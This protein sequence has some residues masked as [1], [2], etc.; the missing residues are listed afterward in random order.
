M[1]TKNILFA[2]VVSG[3]AMFGVSAPAQAGLLSP[4]QNI[5]NQN[6]LILNFDFQGTYVL[7]SSNGTIAQ[8][9]RSG[10]P[11]GGT[12]SLDLF[13]MGGYAD[14]VGDFNTT[15]DPD[16][17][18]PFTAT[19]PLSAYVDLLGSGICDGAPMCASS[20]INFKLPIFSDPINV[21]ADF[22]LDP[23]TPFSNFDPNNPMASLMGL[24]TTQLG[25]QFKISSIDTDG[26]GRPGTQ[27]V[28]GPFNGFTPSFN[29]VA[30]L[31]GITLG[32]ALANP[33]LPAP[34]DFN[35]VLTAP[36]PEPGEWA[37]LLAGLGLVAFKVRGRR[38]A[39]TA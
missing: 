33:N 19:G 2:G 26:D 5:I 12:I 8:R 36:V 25:L 16:G 11:I 13:T 32:Q 9:P 28:G 30:T 34:K 20:K 14:M 35:S 7:T 37:M 24:L 4:V 22:K 31:S 39:A 6:H 10:A 23:I 18:V 38:E 29:G 17:G 3:A 1:S 15:P 27:I 21:L